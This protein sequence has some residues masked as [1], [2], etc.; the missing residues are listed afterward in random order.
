MFN[1]GPTIIIVK[2]RLGAIFGGFTSKSWGGGGVF[3]AD[4][5]AFVFNMN[6]KFIQSN[7]DYSIYNL[8]D[9]F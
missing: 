7:N 1:Q 3:T 5:T 8:N 2:S 4:N 9:R 6:Q